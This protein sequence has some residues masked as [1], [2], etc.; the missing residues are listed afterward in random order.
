MNRRTTCSQAARPACR[1]KASPLVS[2]LTGSSSARDTRQAAGASTNHHAGSVLPHALRSRNP[3]NPRAEIV[4]AVI[5]G[6]FRL[7][8]L[9]AGDGRKTGILV[10]SC[11]TRASRS[12]M[13][14]S[15][16]AGSRSSNSPPPFSLD[17]TDRSMRR[18]RG[19]VLRRS[20][21]AW[22]RKSLAEFRDLPRIERRQLHARRLRSFSIACENRYGPGTSYASGS[23]GNRAASVTAAATCGKSNP[24]RRPPASAF[25]STLSTAAAGSRIRCGR[26]SEPVVRTN[27]LA[28]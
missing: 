13:S 7:V 6:P 27:N 23:T 10:R 25:R 20:G 8:E 2:Y 12:S 19:R 16:F 5:A 21:L 14:R 28:S 18:N 3:R 1:R 22:P 17:A 11:R 4:A 26:L 15:T 9:G 24:L